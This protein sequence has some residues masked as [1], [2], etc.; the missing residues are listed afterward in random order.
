[1]SRAKCRFKKFMRLRA[2]T[3]MVVPRFGVPSSVASRN[4]VPRSR[5]IKVKDLDRSNHHGV[6]SD[7]RTQHRRR[8][9]CDYTGTERRSGF[10]F[11]AH[12]GHSIRGEPAEGMA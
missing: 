2:G 6:D 7:V 11:I 12:G 1:M 3:I 10:P 5:R 9:G 8:Y 4:V